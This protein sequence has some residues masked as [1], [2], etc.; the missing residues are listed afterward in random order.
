VGAAGF[1]WLAELVG[2]RA[3]FLMAGV[4]LMGGALFF[5]RKR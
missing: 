4:F 2:Y 1:G 5:W 3:A